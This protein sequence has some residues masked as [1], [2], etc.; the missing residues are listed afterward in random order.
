MF[1]I[2]FTCKDK[3]TKR[4][5]YMAHIKT[6]FLKLPYICKQSSCEET[7]FDYLT[8]NIHIRKKHDL[9]VDNIINEERCVVSNLP[10]SSSCITNAFNYV[11]IENNDKQMNVDFNEIQDATILENLTAKFKKKAFL[12]T[13]GFKARSRISETV[14]NEFLCEFDDFVKEILHIVVEMAVNTFKED[15]NSE[16]NIKFSSQI[17]SFNH[18][19][20]FINT[21]FKQEKELKKTGTELNL[22]FR[23]SNYFQRRLSL[24]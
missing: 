15:R 9:N 18:P 22:V 8:L 3:F 20:E 12:M 7:F 17:K 2:C 14:L 23:S 24:F 21:K 16:N 13:M 5:L 19:F 10:L 6:H 11:P 4:A 1:L